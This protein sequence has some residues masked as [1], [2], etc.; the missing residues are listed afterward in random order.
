MLVQAADADSSVLLLLAN[1]LQISLTMLAGIASPLHAQLSLGQSLL[2]TVNGLIEVHHPLTDGLQGPLLPVLIGNPLR[3]L[4]FS[5]GGLAFQ[6][7]Y[8][9]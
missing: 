8:L 1:T 7:S 3:Q 5:R 4:G 9:Q 2:E 6:A